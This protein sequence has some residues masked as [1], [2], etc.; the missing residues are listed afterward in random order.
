[1]QEYLS[2][3]VRL[4]WLIN[5]LDKQVEI[6]L[7][8]KSKEVLSLPKAIANEDILPGFILELDTIWN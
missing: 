5:P 2:N 7:P 4:G 8:G 3:G 1:M 6:Y